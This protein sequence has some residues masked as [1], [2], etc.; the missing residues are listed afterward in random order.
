MISQQLLSLIKNKQNL[1][2]IESTL[3]EREKVIEQIQP[4]A[5]Q[6]KLPIYY[7]NQG[8]K[9]LQKVSIEKGL[10]A[11]S[12]QL[13]DG[14]SWLTTHQEKGIYLFSGVLAPNEKG[15]Y[16]P[17]QIASLTNLAFKLRSTN[18]IVI[19]LETYLELPQSLIPFVQIL[20]IPYPSPTEIRSL[21]S[22]QWSLD[23]IEEETLSRLIQVCLA[24]RLGELDLILQRLKANVS[25][26]KDL[27]EAVLAYKKSKFHRKGV[28]FIAQPDVPKAA[29]LELLDAYLQRC[30]ALLRPEAAAHN[31]DFTRGI[32]LWG[33][34]GTGKSL[35]AKLAAQKMGV[36]LIA[37]DWGG[38]RGSNARE[39]RHN[40]TEFLKICDLL[41][42]GGL[43][44]YFDDFDK[45]FAGFDANNDGGAS[46][47]MAG[48]LLTWMQEHTSKV[49]VLA[50]INNLNFLPAEL[51]RRFE[52][53]I[54]FVD[55]PHAGARY[56]IFTL[57]LQK[58]F[59][60]FSLTEK[61]WRKLLD[62]TNLL[63][64]SEIG[65]LVRRTAAEAFYQNSLKLDSKSLATTE[66]HLDLDDLLKQRYLFTPSLIRDEDKI[67]TI[68]NQASFARPASKE[69]NSQWAKR[70]T[71]LFGVAVS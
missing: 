51:I 29:G 50:T 7:W 2:A 5:V 56:E 71:P 59:P 64:P 62:E 23:V 9:Y 68:R 19:C 66:L 69:D 13:F 70:P 15:Q 58:Y 16:S 18:Q 48:K 54:F 35:S 11:S 10:E 3:T 21:I 44:L 36:P 46:R 38:L 33:P 60:N 34:P 65:N 37:A 32:L 27:A 28:E 55:L 42:E 67:V 4:L 30:A 12:H 52:D 41:G 63:T 61:E 24:I 20:S 43:I 57:H 1:I 17:A 22:K 8:F 40:L 53:N 47:Q 39:S 26:P 6:L 14:L 31:L 49:L 25:S 45:G